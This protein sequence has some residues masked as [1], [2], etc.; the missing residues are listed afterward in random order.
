MTITIEKDPKNT[1]CSAFANRLSLAMAGSNLPQRGRAI[2][3]HRRP[4]LNVTAKDA[5]KWV[6]GQSMPAVWRMTIIADLLAV[7]TAWLEYGTAPKETPHQPISVPPKYDDAP[8][9]ATPL[10]ITLAGFA[11][12]TQILQDAATGRISHTDAGQC[13]NAVTGH[14][15]R[16]SACPVCQALIVLNPAV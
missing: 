8:Q 13:P 4:E 16:D 15:S 2:W 1:T 6:N 14:N 9:T 11:S 3:L 12:A 7:D 5:S 10:Q